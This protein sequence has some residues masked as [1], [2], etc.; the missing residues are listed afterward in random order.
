MILPPKNREGAVA[1]LN[2]H[3]VQNIIRTHT[4]CTCL[5]GTISVV[6]DNTELQNAV[7]V[8]L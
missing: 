5:S 7:S 8:E 4:G 2:D 6:F 3:L 1:K